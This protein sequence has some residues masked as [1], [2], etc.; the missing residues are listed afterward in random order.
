[1]RHSDVIVAGAGMAGLLTA[2]ALARRGAHVVLVEPVR[3]G[4]GQSGQSHGYLHQ[5]YAYGPGEPRLPAML[6]SAREHWQYLLAG[7][8]P[9]T[10]SS[11]IAFSDTAAVRRAERY[12]QDSGLAVRPRPTPPWLTGA[13]VACFASAEPTYHIGDILRGLWAQARSAGVEAQPG[14]VL[15]IEEFGHGVRAVLTEPDGRTALVHARAAVLAAGAGTPGLL[16]RSGLPAVVQLRKA[17]MLVLRGRLPAVS[18]LFPERE[19]HGLFLASRIGDDGQTTWL[20]SDFQSFDSS[21]AD[22]GQL[23]GWWS[24]RVLLTLRRV[25]DAAI[26][27]RVDAVSGYP[28]TKSGLLPSSGTVAHEVG[29]EL[30]GGGAVVCTPSKLTLAPL[31]ARRA[32]RT[33]ATRLG[34]PFAEAG[35]DPITPVPTDLTLARET[36]EMP[37]AGLNRADLLSEPPDIGALSEIYHR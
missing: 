24:R 19:E 29:M 16:A 32:V 22:P 13:P 26:L 6:G 37:M 25:V 10:A 20:V 4:G 23:A 14:S 1:M 17:F 30:L 34:M 33:V 21:G 2:L 8:S 27:A 18:V 12:W 5:G 28:A 35:W 36:W 31:A 7:I 3:A 15:R 9:V 11:T